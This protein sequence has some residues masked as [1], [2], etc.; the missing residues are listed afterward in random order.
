M[1]NVRH[2]S[3]TAE[4]F[5]PSEVVEPA[6]RVLGSIDL[7]PASSALV[8]EQLV[9][10]ERFFDAS[11]NGFLAQWSG[12]VFLNPPGGTCDAEGVT[13][14][15]IPDRKG[16]FRPDG[17]PA[18]GQSSQ[19]A[20]W[21]KLMREYTERRVEAAIFVCFSVELLQTTQNQDDDSWLPIPLDF[22]ICYPRKRVDYLRDKG[23]GVLKR[24]GAPPHASAIIYVPPRCLTPQ[25]GSFVDAFSPL[26]RVVVPR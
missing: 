5:T 13:L 21:F 15:K 16:W 22:A 23:D 24:G 14:V 3:A 10:A 1:D 9:K 25:Y 12:T 17:T 20:W 8:N 19:K 18:K 4:H 2:S 7:D 6:R 26:G 11:T